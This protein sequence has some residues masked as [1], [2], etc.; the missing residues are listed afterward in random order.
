M[1]MRVPAASGAGEWNVFSGGRSRPVYV[2]ARV[3]WKKHECVHAQAPVGPCMWW[4]LLQLHFRPH[5]LLLQPE[6]PL[7]SSSMEALLQQTAG[8]DQVPV[9]CFLA[10]DSAACKTPGFA[11]INPW[12]GMGIS[13]DERGFSAS[14]GSQPDSDLLFQLGGGCR[15]VWRL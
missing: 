9:S 5:Q 11:V 14:C 4:G 15:A 1:C 2:R 13:W 8:R 10:W 12:E 3:N 7:G 6:G